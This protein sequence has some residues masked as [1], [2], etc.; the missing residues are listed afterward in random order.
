MTVDTEIDRLRA[1]LAARAEEAGLLDVA[2]RTLDSPVGTLLVA[3][4][5]AGVVRIAYEREGLDA[6][7]ERLATTI[8]PRIIA[9]PARLDPLAHQLDEY[10]AHR[11]ETFDVPTDLGLSAGFRRR[12]LAHLPAIGYGRTASYA[13]VAAAV[14]NPRAVRAVG[15]ACATNP[16]PLVI[17][18]H[19]VVRSDGGVGQYVG[20]ID[21]KRRLLELEAEA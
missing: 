13:A 16:L 1:V 18:S 3:A 6:V 4:T 10:F 8:S 7:L 15:S 20:G 19:R 2:Y 17:P 11:R 12:V 14:D 21:N 5:A 9:A